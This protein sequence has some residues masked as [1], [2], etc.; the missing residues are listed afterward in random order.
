MSLIVSMN[1]L[2]DSL[3]ADSLAIATASAGEVDVEFELVSADN[4]NVFTW[5]IDVNITDQLE[6]ND[7]FDDGS[8]DGSSL[9]KL[10]FF[11]PWFN[12]TELVQIYN[13][14]PELRGV[15]PR[16]IIDSD[17]VRTS[18]ERSEPFPTSLIFI[19][20]TREDQLDIGSLVSYQK[21]T[22]VPKLEANQVYILPSAARSLNVTT[23][24]LI[25]IELYPFGLNDNKNRSEILGLNG[26][27]NLSIASIVK[28]Q[29]R[30]ESGLSNAILLD[31]DM[32]FT[33]FQNYNITTK[34]IANQIVGAFPDVDGIQGGGTYNYRDLEGMKAKTLKIGEK[35]TS[36]LPYDTVF[37]S[38][39]QQYH[40]MFSISFP[41]VQ[42][43]LF[44]AEISTI[45]RVLLDF[46]AAIALI[47]GG[48]LIYS[49]QT[50]SVEE[51]IR[52]FAIMRTVGGKRRQI[53]IMVA[54]EGLSIVTLGSITG[55]FASLGLAPI[56]MRIM[57]FGDIA[58]VI[59]EVSVLTGLVAGLGIGIVSSFLPAYRATATNIVKGLDPLRQSIPE[60]KFSRE[61]GINLT[62][63][64]V[65]IV[66]TITSAI[67][68]VAIPQVLVG[69]GFIWLAFL[70]FG[71]LLVLLI[72]L[73]LI[74]VALLIPVMEFL[75]S[76]PLELF[77]KTR[78]VKDI[79]VRSLRRNRRRTTATAVMFSLSFA[80]VFFVGVTMEV[81]AATAEYN[82]I[83]SNG[84]DVVLTSQRTGFFFF[85]FGSRDKVYY[86]INYG[87]QIKNRFLEQERHR[88]GNDSL[89][90]KRYNRSLSFT[91]VTP[92]LS[93]ARTMFSLTEGNETKEYDA[94]VRIGDASF[95]DSLSA[96]IYGIAPNFLDI[97]YNRITFSQGSL[98]D[99][100][101]VAEGELNTAVISTGLASEFNLKRGDPFRLRI[102]TF[103][104][105]YDILNLT[106]KAVLD[107]A[108]GFSGFSTGTGFGGSDVWVSQETWQSLRQI[109]HSEKLL[110]PFGYLPIEKIFFKI[111]DPEAGHDPD[112]KLELG[113][114]LGEFLSI[115][116]P[117]AANEVT[118][119]EVENAKES[120]ASG[121]A[122]FSTIMS[123]AVIISFFGL[124]SSMYSS[125][126]ESQFEIGVLKSMG[127]RNGDVRNYLIFESTI[128]TLSSGACG[129][130]IGYILAYTFE[131]QSASF[132]ESPIIFVVPWFL[133]T[134]LFVTSII[135]GILGAVIP[136]RIVVSKSPVEILRRG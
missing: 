92:D 10:G 120:A 82:A 46:M 8:W 91:E 132:S 30:F 71:L 61:R 128:L 119:E 34:E 79:V 7:V 41:R 53:W 127:L 106:V 51:R 64:G 114:K 31:Y 108:P 22:P 135:V 29:E 103:N 68:V 50:V 85:F 115:Y 19:N 65:G 122:L 33:I 21:N 112:F 42:A 95:F 124:M 38:E 113:K 52:D 55:I 26:T 123:L 57:R 84:S 94:S 116:Y 32:L 4:H 83:M 136:G 56:F 24:D 59:S 110:A 73:D 37:P 70:I 49:L 107:A 35:L 18:S 99:I 28:N 5:A 101:A 111:E 44:I 109:I 105:T 133:L 3:A 98:T 47:I 11:R 13:K 14:Q 130:L 27:I 40:I 23:G 6:I 48:V 125:V 77:R 2:I 1:V 131:F 39:D 86:P 69:G 89:E 100:T 134:F 81:D 104:A 126:Q 36:L 90:L 17:Y 43:I 102:S 63:L 12:A 66:L 117:D 58:L 15:S 121:Q 9:T 72:G 74:S 118:V 96:N 78:K 75:F 62:L 129:A 97:L 67:V 93:Y 25:E 87:E 76:L 60:A 88:L 45:A 54:I 80:F 16:L 20:T